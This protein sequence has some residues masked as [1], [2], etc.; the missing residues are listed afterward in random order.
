MEGWLCKLGLKNGQ[1][2][3]GYASEGRVRHYTKVDIAAGE[4]V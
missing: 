1:N 2:S 4:W 3:T